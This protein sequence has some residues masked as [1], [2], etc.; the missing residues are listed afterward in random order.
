MVSDLGELVVV[1]KLDQAVPVP[2]G[3]YRLSNVK[4]EIPV[5]DGK[6][7]TYN[8]DSQTSKNY[9]VPTGGE[10]TVALLRQLAMQVTIDLRG[11]KA[12]P[13]ETL[14]IQPKLTA[15]RSLYLSSCRIGKGDEF[16][17][18]EGNAEIVLLR[19]RKGGQSG[20][21]RLFVRRLLLALVSSAQRRPRQVYRANHLR[22]GTVGRQ[23]YR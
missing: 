10:T 14:S 3:E 8:F 22:S 12:A 7:W 20:P 1:D 6:S 17:R 19:R 9:S 21:E 4:L 5:A 11:G 16:Q 2:F 18:A 15:D 13:G 23:D